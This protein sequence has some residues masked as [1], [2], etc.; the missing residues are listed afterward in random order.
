[1]NYYLL[2]ASCLMTHLPIS[3][4]DSPPPDLDHSY[5]LKALGLIPPINLKDI[6]NQ[7]GK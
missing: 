1:M 3:P 6:K 7:Q 4:E 5:E 2:K